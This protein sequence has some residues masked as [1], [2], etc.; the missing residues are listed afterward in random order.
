MDLTE[1]LRGRLWASF[2]DVLGYGHFEAG[3][4]PEEASAADSKILEAHK[5][6][7]AALLRAVG[8]RLVEL[9]DE[10]DADVRIN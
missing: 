7:P 2:A 10:I 8:L 5:D 1:K 4:T 9:A 6:G 3:H